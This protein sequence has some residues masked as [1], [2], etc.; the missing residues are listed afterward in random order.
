MH[1]YIHL[2]D[3]FNACLEACSSSTQQ[4]QNG[5]KPPAVL[6]HG[7]SNVS[8][9]SLC[10]HPPP[11]KTKPGAVRFPGG[12]TV[13]HPPWVSPTVTA[14]SAQTRCR[15]RGVLYAITYQYG[16]RKFGRQRLK[17]WP[18]P[19]NSQ[20]VSDWMVNPRILT[21]DGIFGTISTKI[22]RC[23]CWD[24]ST[25]TRQKC[26]LHPSCDRGRIAHKMLQTDVDAKH[27]IS[28]KG[29]PSTTVVW[30]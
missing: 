25:L 5:Q 11:P 24:R 14:R 4:A 18:W 28:A 15:H 23:Y 2:N 27:T 8:C 21:G 12:Y 9:P 22:N 10:H 3:K 29:L 17:H 30:Y 6:F 16:L 19:Q 13:Y 1:I 7:S 26:S 20:L